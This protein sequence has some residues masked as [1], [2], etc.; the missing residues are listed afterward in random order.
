MKHSFKGKFRLISDRT[1]MFENVNDR[2]NSTGERRRPPSKQAD[3]E[4][5]KEDNIDKN[6]QY[7]YPNTRI[8]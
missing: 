1:V 5:K 3:K 6:R 4:N 7:K 8:H 2:K